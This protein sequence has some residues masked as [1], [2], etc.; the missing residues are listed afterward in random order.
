M[1]IIMQLCNDSQPI[2]NHVDFQVPQLVVFDFDGV[3]TDNMV[4]MNQNGE[5]MVRC[6]RADGLGIKMLKQKNIPAFILSTETN[7][8]VTMRAN[9]LG[10]TVFQGCE[11]KRAFLEN[12]LQEKQIDP[13]NVVYIGNDINDMDVMLYVGWPVC[14]AD[15]Y[16]E[17]LKISSVVLQ[18]KG[19]QGAVRE[20]CQL[21]IQL[22]EKNEQR[23]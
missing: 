21:L 23:T 6:S 2:N 22:I 7:P 9:K 20:F 16:S 19:G 3:F 11:D 15:A 14:P 4:Y 10:L 12:Y 1:G 18:N 8:V 5:E 17:I 13:Q